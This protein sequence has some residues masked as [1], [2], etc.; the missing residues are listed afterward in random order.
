MVVNVL[1]IRPYSFSRDVFSKVIG[2]ITPLNLGF[3]AGF[4]NRRLNI[5]GKKVNIEILDMEVDRL[6]PDEFA[7]K[8]RIFKP[9]LVGFTTYTNTLPI[10]KY[11]SNIVKRVRKH[12]LIVLGGPHPSV[13]PVATLQ[14]GKNFDLVVPGEGELVLHDIVQFLL[15]KN[16]NISEINGIYYKDGSNGEVHHSSKRGL[17]RDISIFYPPDRSLLHQEKYLD[18]PQSPG[19]WKR[20][21]NI[22]TQRGC[23]F[24][25]TFCAS[26]E[27]HGKVVRFFPLDK[28]FKDIDES[29]KKYNIKH[30]TFRDS[31][32]TINKKR[33]I[34]LCQEFINRD[35]NVTWNCE[36]RVDLVDDALLKLM[37]RAGC[38]KISF[39]VESGSQKILNQAR[40]NINIKKII[41][42][43]NTCSKLGI[44]TQAYFMVGFPNETLQDIYKTWQLILKI[45]PDFLFISILVPLPGTFIHDHFIKNKA[46]LT[47]KDLISFQFFN[48]KPVWNLN[49]LPPKTLVHYQKQIYR[50]YVINPRYFIRMI[51]KIRELG[52]LRYY[53]IAFVDFILFLIKR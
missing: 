49:G 28:I 5:N 48:G 42:T 53:M 36:T 31:N 4:L 9:D 10:V 2:S 11:L 6:N 51:K 29:I 18:K 43:F 26:P 37:K 34:R 14:Y 33:C 22:F 13:E 50:R 23:P 30:I 27:I 39:G 41:D 20:T 12:V 47:E 38:T 8:I 46:A 44:S 40:K 1:L 17:A 52:Q 21:I 19:I 35:W 15:E 25:C 16:K 45:K 32:F 24:S 3:L 7:E